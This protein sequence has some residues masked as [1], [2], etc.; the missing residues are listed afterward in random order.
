VEEADG[1]S[2]TRN[3]SSFGWTLGH[4]GVPRHQS[5]GRTS[6]PAA[7]PTGGSGV[8]RVVWVLLVVAGGTVLIVVGLAV[9]AALA[10]VAAAL[11]ALACT[12]GGDSSP[13]REY[14]SWVDDERVIYGSGG[15]PT[16]VGDQRVVTG[17]SGGPSWIGD[18]RVVYGSDGRPAWIG[19]DRVVYKENGEIGWIGDHKVH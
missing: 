4:G 6:Q 16:W 5:T 15:V 7:N 19:N 11:I 18:K 17:S 2:G 1:T 3:Q 14:G 10:I 13:K 8:A 12:L 9:L